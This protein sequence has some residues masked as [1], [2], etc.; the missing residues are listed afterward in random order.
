MKLYANIFEPA[1]RR[2]DLYLK[3]LNEP[4]QLMEQAEIEGSGSAAVDIKS[5][6]QASVVLETPD[7]EHIFEAMAILNY[8]D[9]KFGQPL[10][11]KQQQRASVLSALAEDFFR[12][13]QLSLLH[14]SPYNARRLTQCQAV[15]LISQV[16]WR[17][18]L[19]QI[20]EIMD[21]SRFL[22][23]DHWTMTDANLFAQLE[24]ATTC[25]G[26]LIPP[27]LKALYDWRDRFSAL[28]GVKPLCLPEDYF[29]AMV[30]KFGNWY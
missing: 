26:F 22:V 8:L 4:Y 14:T 24:C 30:S 19:E 20:A 16:F 10:T 7:G 9:E 5:L 12:Y 28:P 3:L 15:D 27:H 1:G 23:A 18:R 29:E 6:R 25:F 11:K 17:A 2:I 21:T 13:L